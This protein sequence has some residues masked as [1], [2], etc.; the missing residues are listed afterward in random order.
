MSFSSSLLLSKS[1]CSKISTDYN[2]DMQLFPFNS[3]TRTSRNSHKIPF[4]E[5]YKNCIC[6]SLLFGCCIC[7]T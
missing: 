1:K 5:I 2:H 7:C 4:C 6:L 3:V